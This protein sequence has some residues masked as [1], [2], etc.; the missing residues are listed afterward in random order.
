MSL[1]YNESLIIRAFECDQPMGSMIS[2]VVE[3]KID[4]DEKHLRA[5]DFL[6]ARMN[7]NF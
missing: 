5:S 2:F 3:A 4:C 1:S 6:S 7:Q